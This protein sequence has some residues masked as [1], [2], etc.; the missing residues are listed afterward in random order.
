M[1]NNTQVQNAPDK[2]TDEQEKTAV[3]GFYNRACKPYD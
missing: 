3:Q 2:L 1:E